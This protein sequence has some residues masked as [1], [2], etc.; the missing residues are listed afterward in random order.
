[1]KILIASDSRGIA[2][3]SFV[4]YNKFKKK[5]YTWIRYFQKLMSG[6]EISFHNTIGI[7][8]KGIILKGSARRILTLYGVANEIEKSNEFYDLIIVQLGAMEWITSWNIGVLNLLVSERNEKLKTECLFATPDDGL[9][10]YKDKELVEKCFIKIKKH[11]K[12]MLVIG[13]HSWL[14]RPGTKRRDLSH[15]CYHES[16]LEMNDIYSKIG[17]F[18]NLPMSYDWS[19]NNVFDYLHYNDRGHKYISSFVHRYTNRMNETILDRLN[20]RDNSNF[21]V[22]N[23]NKKTFKEF[24]KNCRVAGSSIAKLTKENDVVLIS[25]RTSFEQ[26]E[27]FFGCILT[28]RIPLIVQHPSSKIDKLFFDDKITKINNMCFPS[29]CIVDLCDFDLFEN[30]FKNKTITHI[31][32]TNEELPKVNIDR[33]DVAFIQLSSGTTGNPKILKVTHKA[34]IDQCDEYGNNINIDKNKDVIISWLPLYHDMGLIACTML[35]VLSGCSFVHL[36][37]FDWLKSPSRLF[38]LIN[39][40]KGSLVW[41]PNFAFS[42]LTSNIEDKSDLSSMR[43]WINCSEMCNCKTI[44]DFYEK[45]KNNGVTLN[46]ISSCYALA[47]NVFAVSQS[48]GF[49][50][51]D[52]DGEKVVCCGE[53]IPGSSCIIVKDKKDVTNIDKGQIFIKSSYMS[54]GIDTS[55][56]GY[57]Y[58]GDI[59]FIRDE[60]LYILGRNDDAIIS[61]GNNFFPYDIEKWVSDNCKCIPGRVAC[62]GIYNKNR[63][64]QEVHVCLEAEEDFSDHNKFDLCSSIFNKYSISITCHVF[65]RG[66]IIKTSSGKINRKETSKKLLMELGCV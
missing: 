11:C 18:L 63:G 60:K 17:D 23:E 35:P 48:K 51:M 34:I 15:Y 56:H 32:Y 43:L 65:N 52:F 6:H 49:E 38:S 64:T 36:H 57:Y 45:F 2:T 53:V 9:Y 61:Y 21:I 54:T 62:V 25:K 16:V 29:L 8:K 1:M 33:N 4:E 24:F 26:I 10:L 66:W 39:K 22:I 50:T 59:G 58:T 40:Y 31:E 44:L 5:E 30:I 19:K 13:M 37:T 47:E 27:C 46:S 7:I 14:L 12:N 41:M 42:Y 3:R 20:I 28:K 55:F